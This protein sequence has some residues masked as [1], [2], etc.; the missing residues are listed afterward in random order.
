MK[1]I[2]GA[3]TACVVCPVSKILFMEKEINI[4]SEETG[5]MV[6]RRFYKELTDIQ[7]SW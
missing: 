4:P 7:K 1:E 3:G 2:F 6:A 5:G